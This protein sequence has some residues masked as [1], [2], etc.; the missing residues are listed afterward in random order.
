MNCVELP[1]KLIGQVQRAPLDEGKGVIGLIYDV[2]TD[3]LKARTV[4]AHRR[5]ASTTE[6]IQ[7]FW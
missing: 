1:E 2:N 7:Q 6:E 4:I 3:Y 5:T